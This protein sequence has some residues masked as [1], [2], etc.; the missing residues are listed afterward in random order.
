MRERPRT[1]AKH[2]A[3]GIIVFE[4]FFLA[5]LLLKLTHQTDLPWWLVTLP[6][7]GIPMML[8]SGVMAFMAW[9]AACNLDRQRLSY[10]A[11]RDAEADLPPKK[12]PGNC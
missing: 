12:I 3:T 9:K 2:T 11:R 5:L 8:A 10:N 1:I 4:L 7:W 6:L